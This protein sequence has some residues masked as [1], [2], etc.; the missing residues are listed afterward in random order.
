[1]GYK[2]DGRVGGGDGEWGEGGGG[3]D[4][5]GHIGD[6][7]ESNLNETWNLMIIESFKS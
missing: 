1:M 5:I 4:E 2:L 6:K 7:G 3:K